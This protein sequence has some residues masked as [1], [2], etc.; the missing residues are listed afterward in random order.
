MCDSLILNFLLSFDTV[1]YNDISLINLPLSI[2]NCSMLI[3]V[4][5]NRIDCI[6]EFLI[7]DGIAKSSTVSSKFSTLLTTLMPLTNTTHF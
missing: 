4:V 2:I 7:S 3:M 1:V 6:D 5:F